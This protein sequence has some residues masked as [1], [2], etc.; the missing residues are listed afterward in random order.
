MQQFYSNGKLLLTGEYVVLDGAISLAVPTK[1]G[2]TLKVETID[3]P[4]IQWKSLDE[5][6][7]LW[8]E[9]DFEIANNLP[10]PLKWNDTSDRL[11]QIFKALK[12]LKPDVFNL[13]QGLK[14]TTILDFPT[15]WGLGTSSTLINNLAQ[16]AK[17]DAFKLLELT[18]GG[19]G[20]DIA[21]AQN[22]TP[23]TYKLGQVPPMVDNVSFDPIFKAHLYFVHLNKKQNSREGIAHYR[24]QNKDHIRDVISDINSITSK[25][26]SCN[27]LEAFKALINQHE[28]I[29]AKV[30]N[31]KTVKE[32]LFND[33][34]GSIK[35]LGAWGGDFVLA[36]SKTNPR[37]YFKRMGFDTIIPYSE[38][39]L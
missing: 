39:V 21:C 28:T 22:N 36:A 7:A 29:I 8:F 10:Q 16:W 32:L 3:K 31:Q 35:S 30:T 14:I 6:G 37:D 25:M 11:L 20:Y 19:S 38:M 2:Q 13:K 5:N 33:F 12:L 4:T 1:Y 15:N 24:A 18:F 27:T 23:I 26:I 17:V 9:G 34:K